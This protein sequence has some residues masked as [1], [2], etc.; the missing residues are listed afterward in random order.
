MAITT[1]T[2]SQAAN[3]TTSTVT[4]PASTA[5]GDM[6]LALVSED[7]GAASNTWTVGWTEVLDSAVQSVIVAAA[8]YKIATGAE[9]DPVA[10]HTTERSNHIAVRIPAAEWANDGTAPVMSTL[11]TNAG[12]AAPDPGSVTFG[13]SAT[14]ET[15]FVA[16][17]Y[18]DRSVAVTM[19]TWPTGYTANQVSNVTA[20]SAG[21]VAIA[22]KPSSAASSPEDPGAFGLSGSEQWGAVVFAIKGIA[23]AAAA[24][25]P[26]RKPIVQLL[27]H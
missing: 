21:D 19:S 9:S 2:S 10:T 13:W 27:S 16:V 25:Q 11:V 15:I 3:S 24:N 6:L 12:S 26:Y 8:A 23:L 7:S 1:A 22:V 18:W 17:A 14:N 5:S 20:T 4:L